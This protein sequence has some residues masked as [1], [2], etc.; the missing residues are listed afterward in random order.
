[1][2]RLGSFNADVMAAV[3]AALASGSPA[4]STGGPATAANSVLATIDTTGFQSLAVQLAGVWSGNVIFQASNDGAVWVPA[5]GQAGS[6]ISY[7]FGDQGI[8]VLPVQSRYLQILTDG[9]FGGAVSW[10]A[11][12]LVAPFVLPQAVPPTQAVN[13][14]AS[15]GLSQDAPTYT[16]L[17]G[18]PGGDFV[19]TN[20]LELAMTEGSGIALNTRP[21]NLPRVDVTNALALSDA[22]A[23]IQISGGA[24]QYAIIDTAGYESVNITTQA[25]AGTV[26]ASN[27]GITW[28]ALTGTP[29]VLGALVTAVTANAGFAFPALARY[30]KVTITTAGTATAYLRMQTWS[31][32]YTTSVPT[33]TSSNNV[34]QLA[35]T[36]PVT[37]GVAGTLA[38]GG[39]IAPGTAPT[40]QPVGV[41]GIDAGNLT[42]RLLTDVV[43]RQVVLGAG[44]TTT[45]NVPAVVVA[46]GAL[47]EG[48]SQSD[49]LIQ[50]LLEM[51]IT[52]QYL[53]DM[54]RGNMTTD[55]PQNYRNDPSVFIQ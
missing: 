15:A 22:P 41:A 31:G 37:A 7:S 23:P 45:H 48:A 49:L 1:M 35:G 26:T 28:S 43:G 24:G 6:I 50:L 25:L 12:L 8:I 18:D 38:I 39:N 30:I 16:V 55:E 14:A 20:P 52:N 5:I 3:T 51:R 17:T 32:S 34:A 27:D 33:S 46:D 10:N 53:Y 21:L 29:L 2:Q 42:R 54:A 9:G 13:N 4:A 40:L 19:G 36:A 47:A 44:I 11:Y